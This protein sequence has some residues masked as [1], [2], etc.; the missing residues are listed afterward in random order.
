MQ[1]F[2]YINAFWRYGSHKNQVTLEVIGYFEMAGICPTTPSR[3]LENH[4]I[5]FT[6]VQK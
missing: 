4:N 6:A 1:N 5:R 2:R 3:Y